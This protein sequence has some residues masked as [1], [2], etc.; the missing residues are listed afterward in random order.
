M[1]E[2]G[3]NRVTDWFGG[4][5][6]SRLNDKDTGRIIVVMQRLHEDDLAGHLLQARGWHHLDLPAIAVEDSD[7]AIGSNRVFRRRAGDLLHPRRE[8]KSVLER[9]KAEIG[10]LQFSAQYQQRPVP[11]EGN[12]IKRDWLRWYV[13]LPGA[14][15]DYV[16]QSWDT[17]MGGQRLLGL[18]HLAHDQECLLPRRSLPRPTPISRPAARPGRAGDKI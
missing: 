14:G 5:L 3:R 8:S 15:A 10:S 4:T 11:L 7:I 6:V 16:V 9:I 1:S 17:A 2:P 13:Q 18:H 12:L